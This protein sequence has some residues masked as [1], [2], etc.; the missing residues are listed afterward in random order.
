MSAAYSFLSSSPPA[1]LDD[2]VVLHRGVSHLVASAVSSS[3]HTGLS[4][5][6][7]SLSCGGGGD[8]ASST[9]SLSR[10]RLPVSGK[11]M[12]KLSHIHATSPDAS[13]HDRSMT[14]ID[15]SRPTH[16]DR[17]LK[18]REEDGSGFASSSRSHSRESFGGAGE[19]PSDLWNACRRGSAVFVEFFLRDNPSV[20]RHL[21]YDILFD[22][23]RFDLTPLRRKC[24]VHCRQHF[25]LI[26]LRDSCVRLD[27]WSTCSH[28]SPLFNDFS[29][30]KRLAGCFVFVCMAEKFFLVATSGEMQLN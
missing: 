26:D 30:E 1:T 13:I 2:D 16:L 25:F 8:E 22:H 12:S 6:S 3:P 24:N 28:Q 11:K 10:S 23:F 21:C 29:V 19:F 14:T 17:F 4:S 18:S 7:P 20:V 5:S 15:T 9:L 27:A